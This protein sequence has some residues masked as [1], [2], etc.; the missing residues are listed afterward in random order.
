MVIGYN[1][2]QEPERVTA[3]ENIMMLAGG[4]GILNTILLCVELFETK[5]T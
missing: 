5:K 3:R 1:Y 4:A 2:S